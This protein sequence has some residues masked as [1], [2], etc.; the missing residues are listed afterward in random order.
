MSGKVMRHEVNATV[1]KTTAAKATGRRDLFSFFSSR[2]CSSA[3]ILAAAV[4]LQSDATD[5]LRKEGNVVADWRCCYSPSPQQVSAFICFRQ[6][7][8]SS[9][10]SLPSLFPS[11]ISSRIPFPLKP[12]HSLHL[13]SIYVFLSSFSLLVN[14]FHLPQETLQRPFDY[15]IS[16]HLAL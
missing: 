10:M 7:S 14:L 3:F 2:S 8:T 4:I 9:S 11:S 12:L 13:L 1:E 15:F 16:F 5:W 6:R